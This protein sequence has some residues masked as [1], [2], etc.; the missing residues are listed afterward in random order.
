[1]KIKITAILI[2]SIFMIATVLPVS[3]SNVEIEKENVSSAGMLRN[4]NLDLAITNAGSNQVNIFLGDGS[5]EFENS[6]NFSVGN[7]PVGIIDGDFN[8]DGILDIITTDYEDA[9][10]TLLI[11]DGTGS[12]ALTARFPV[13]LEPLGIIDEDFNGD[14]K[15]D[16]AVA[17]SGSNKVSVLIGDGASGFAPQQTFTVGNGP[18]DLCSGMFDG[19]SNVDLISANL[20]SNSIALLTGDGEGGF[21]LADT[22]DL[23]YDYQPYAISKGDFDKDGNM[24]VVVASGGYPDI[25]VLLGDGAGGFDPLQNFTVGLGLERFDIV[26]EDFNNDENLDIAV[27]NTNEDTIS[28]LLGNGT[29]GFG[30]H[31]TF[32]VGAYPVGI[33]D[34]DFDEDGDPDL[35]VTNA[36]D[37]TVSVLIGNG[38]GGFSTQQ[39]LFAGEV[40][41]GILS[42]NIDHIPVPDLECN[43]SLYWTGIKPGADIIDSFSIGNT[44][45]VSSVLKW[46]IQSYPSWGEWSFSETSGNI[47]DATWEEI[48]VL[49]TAPNES[50][51]FTGTI[52]IINL[53]DPNDECEIEV[54]VKTPRTKTLFESLLELILERFPN[55]FPILRQ[56]LMR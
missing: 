46:K 17:N 23:G 40:P 27:P 15:I 32:V 22:I 14:G 9:N 31:Q 43:G 18:V 16:I 38:A 1:M 8:L 55:A 7:F 35:A 33:C 13:D 47:P 10:V 21:V 3:G 37:N 19:D 41:V 20:D 11:G 56:I 45:E 39:I 30:T 26:V 24:D 34:G 12:F 48:Q 25:G 44:G 4:L 50:D 49:I 5:G 36:F 29:G 52:K 28:V 42:G 54:Y 2:C 6:G 51:T 53:E